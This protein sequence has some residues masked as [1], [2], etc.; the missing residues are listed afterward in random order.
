MTPADVSNLIAKQIATVGHTW[1]ADPRNNPHGL[2]LKRCLVHPARVTCQNPFPGLHE[3]APFDAWL[4]LQ[5]RPD[6]DAGAGYS[7]I[8]EEEAGQFGL[9]CGT[10]DD[11]VLIGLYGSF[12]DTVQGM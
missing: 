10:R 3:G 12:L 2:D 8:F 9:A 1:F 4:V 6:D 5:E 7:I 11:L